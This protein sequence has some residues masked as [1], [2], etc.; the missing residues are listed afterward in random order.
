MAGCGSTGLTRPA[1]GMTET[2]EQ[3]PPL[4]DALLDRLAPGIDPSQVVAL[5]RAGK[6]LPVLGLVRALFAASPADFLVRMAV[7]LEL[8][9]VDGRFDREQIRIRVPFVAREALDAAVEAL[10]RGG[11]L[12]LRA[13]DNTYR[14]IPLGS[15]LLTVLVAGDFEAQ[16]PTNMLV[17]AAEALLFGDRVDATGDTTAQL[18][19]VLLAE[20][21]TQAAMATDVIRSGRPTLLVRFSRTEVRQQIGQVADVLAALEK[22]HGGVA[23][24]TRH[25]GRVVRLHEAMQRILR[26]HESLAKRLAEWNLKQLETTDAG[27][28]LMA[29]SDAVLGASAEE[30][31]R[32]P[33]VRPARCPAVATRRLLS[34]HQ[35]SRKTVK[36]ASKRFVYRAPPEPEAGALSLTDIDPVARA[37]QSLA[38]ALEANER[39]PIGEWLEAEA[40]DFADA[41]FLLALVARLSRGGSAVLSAGVRARI[42]EPG[43]D[44]RDAPGNTQD[45]LVALVERGGLTEVSGRGLHT[46]LTLTREGDPGHG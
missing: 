21:E 19:G 33:V 26:A 18:L 5:G 17:R 32:A 24:T 30:L 29:L 4:E 9:G 15:Y 14:L 39:L 28:S 3:A 40:V 45:A 36:N 42:E 34:R 12:E 38:T 10:A 13:V 7:L 11:W 27:Y 46:A 37:A 22:R 20:L 41:A 31:R 25:F 43:V 2:E 44:A 16:S 6:V 1:G 23:G 8:A 35:S